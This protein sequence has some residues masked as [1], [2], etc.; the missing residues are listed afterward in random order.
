MILNNII[1]LIYITKKKKV[2]FRQNRSISI[3]QDRKEI[4]TY[5]KHNKI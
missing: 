4:V 2:I 1:S 3:I 5:K